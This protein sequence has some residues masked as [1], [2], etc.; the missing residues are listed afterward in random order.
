VC[1]CVC[2]CVQGSR[3]TSRMG[4]RG[5]SPP[6][7]A[8]DDDEMNFEASLMKKLKRVREREGVCVGVCV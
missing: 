2:V 7:G 4:S 5:G 6:P 3:M 1:A 8:A